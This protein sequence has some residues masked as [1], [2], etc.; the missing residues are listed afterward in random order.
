MNSKRRFGLILV[1][2]LMAL[3]GI[4]MIAWSG[5]EQ[6][7][8]AAVNP[9]SKIENRKSAVPSDGTE[10]LPPGVTIQT[11]LPNM[12]YPIA[13]AFDP[14]G[15]LFYT[16]KVSGKVR[17]FENGTLRASAV[18]TFSVDSAGERGLLGIAIDPNFNANHY[19]Y[20][21]HTCGTS[22]G[23]PSNY[24]NRVVRFVENNGA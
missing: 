3:A 18:I 7:Q 23:C 12:A 1:L 17:L 6:S 16:E 5:G 2:L 11:L 22:N 14:N 21:Y 4:S 8:A 20:V 13:M 19:I 9:K 10:P 15:R 24:E